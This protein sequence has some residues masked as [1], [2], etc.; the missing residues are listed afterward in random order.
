MINNELLIK[1]NWNKL[2]YSHFIDNLILLK[3]EKLI[4]FNSKLIYTKSKI[5]GIKT[6]VLREIA[7]NI[8]KGNIESFLL[9]CENNYFEVTL[10][11]GFVIGYI[12]D[13]ELFLKYFNKFIKKVDNWAVCD[14][15]VSSFK[16]MKKYDFFD[17]AKELSLSCDEFLSRVGIIIM[18]DHYLNEKYIDD[19]IET[20][21][22]IKSD[23]YYVNMAIAWL[24]SVMYIKFKDKTLPLLE[25]RI[26][27]SFVQ[28]KSIQKI[29]DS[30]RVNSLDKRMLIKYKI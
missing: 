18:L 26:L 24:I 22:S 20:I 9:N 23:Y 3:D 10:I 6:P 15:C 17:I 30:Y 2:D 8:A 16:I 5:I 7:K 28:N 4:D 12:K 29:R 27:P 1:D 25:K 13:K 19:I 11:E 14:M 21:I